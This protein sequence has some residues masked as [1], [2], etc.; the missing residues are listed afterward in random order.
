MVLID[1]NKLNIA[2]ARPAAAFAANANITAIDLSTYVGSVALVVN[3]GAATAGSSPTLD[4]YLQSGS[5]SNGANA[6]NLNVSA[7]Q[8]T[9]TN[10]HQVLTV[11]TRAAGKYLKIVKVIGGTSSPSFP[12]G[13]T[14]VGQKRSV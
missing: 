7:T 12:L 2:V 11:D 1:P 3:A 6:T 9:A 14:I 4:I 5:E 13:L 10:S 8:V